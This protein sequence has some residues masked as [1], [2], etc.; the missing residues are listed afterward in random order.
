[1]SLLE[2]SR[3]AL[4]ARAPGMFPKYEFIV[5]TGDEVSKARKFWLT[6]QSLD[7]EFA[8]RF[9]LSVVGCAGIRRFRDYIVAPVVSGGDVR[10]VQVSKP[11]KSKMWPSISFSGCAHVLIRPRAAIT[12]VTASIMPALAIFQSMR[13]ANVVC[14]FD[15][16]NAV[17]AASNLGIMGS[18]VFVASSRDTAKLEAQ[19]DKFGAGFAKFQGIEGCDAADA[20]R[21]WGEQAPGRIR[22]TV[23]AASRYVARA[24]QMQ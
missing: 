21:E 16:E 24:K 12:C 15:D 14:S 13:M 22:R 6:C 3:Q 8:Q 10:S 1:M 11:G 20:M 4:R 17:A 9:G 23:E 18:V 19:A 7:S 2:Q 5:D